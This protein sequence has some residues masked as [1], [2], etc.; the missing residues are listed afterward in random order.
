[1]SREVRRA[2]LDVDVATDGVRIPVARAAVTS[3]VRA[4]LRGE[5]VHHALVSIAFVTRARIAALNRAH[6]D[7]RGATDV[8]A[9]GFRRVADGDAV[10]GD[11]YICP[12]VARASA[13]ALGVPMR[14]ELMR[15]VV[16]GTLHVL[17]Y[18][19]PEDEARHDSVMWTKQEQIVRRLVVSRHRA[20]TR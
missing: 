14:E 20:R 2:R 9:F 3:A 11:V 19:H 4:V 12:D 8:I 16:H 18:D 15:L 17:G 1:M 13:R 5:A 10:V 7:R 6:L